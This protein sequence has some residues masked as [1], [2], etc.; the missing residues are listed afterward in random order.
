[1]LLSD[2]TWGMPHVPI[3]VAVAHCASVGFDGLELTVIPG[4]STDAATLDV[5]ARRRIRK[6]YDDHEL[7]LCGLSG[8]TPLLDPDPGERAEHLRRLRSYLDLAAELQR[9]GER[10]SV[11]TTTG[12]A[13]AAWDDVKDSLVAI[14]G[15]LAAYAAQ[16]GVIVGIE[17]HVG[18][19]V[20]HPD[21]V[22]WLIDQVRSPALT[23]HFDISHFN[24]Q[25][26]AMEPVIAQLAPHCAHTHVKDERGL[27]PDHEFLIPGEGDMDYVA[28]LRAMAR[29]GYT[30]HIVV[31]ISLMVQRRP[32][33]DPLDAATRSYRVLAQAFRDA[34]IART[35]DQ[36]PTG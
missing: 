6:L 22:L 1:M 23:V 24:V 35:L 8:N 20:R 16:A 36:S 25:G 27:A 34:G 12:G 21:Q 3:D 28:Y 4:W 2:S 29:A 7:A 26:L 33:Y 18:T 32:D 10:L 15:E 14:F 11:S 17:P 31:E 13:A 5:T 30:G 19:A 9:P